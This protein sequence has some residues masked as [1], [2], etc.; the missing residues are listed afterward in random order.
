MFHTGLITERKLN[1]AIADAKSADRIPRDVPP[2]LC[3][4]GTERQLVWH[5]KLMAAAVRVDFDGKIWVSY[6]MPYAAG[7]FF[8]K[9]LINV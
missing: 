1:R 7:S 6:A 2:A 5:D 9:D 3:L 4:Y 8:E